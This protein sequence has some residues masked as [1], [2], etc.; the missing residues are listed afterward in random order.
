MSAG[1][2]IRAIAADLAQAERRAHWD[3]YLLQ[4]NL[5]ECS[6]CRSWVFNTPS[7]V[8]FHYRR[9]EGK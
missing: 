1:E 7:A 5:A 3:Q 4:F 2:T 9:C 8:R 6:E